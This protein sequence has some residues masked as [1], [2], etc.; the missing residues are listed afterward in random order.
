MNKYLLMCV[1]I[2][3]PVGAWAAYQNPIIERNELQ[4][5]GMVKLFLLIRGNAGEP[6]VR[7]ELLVRPGMTFTQGRYWADDKLNELDSARTASNAAQLQPGQTIP[8]LARP[9]VVPTAKE[10]WRKKFNAY[11]AVKDSGLAGA[12]L[13]SD[14]AAKKAD[15]EATYATGFLDE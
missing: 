15:L 13:A 11:M 4:P 2:L 6:D 10:V 9:P 7:A 8:R 12:T 3:L 1:L 5:N 14:L